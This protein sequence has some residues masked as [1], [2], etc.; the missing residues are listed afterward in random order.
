MADEAGEAAQASGAAEPAS[1]AT[2]PQKLLVMIVSDADAD[3]LMRR[4]VESGSPATKVG[5]TGGFLRKGNATLF[6]GVPEDK[7]ESILTLIR[8]ECHARTEYVPVQTLP[9][10]GE[11]AY[12]SDQ[13][14]VRMGGA[15]VFVMSVERFEKV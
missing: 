6:S 12:M 8:E 5:S 15:I 4:L 2:G 9:F 14:Q 3:R 10:I 13:L 7:V 1:E 11:G